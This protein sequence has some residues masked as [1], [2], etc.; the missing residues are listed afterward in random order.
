MNACVVAVF[1]VKTEP[2]P[3]VSTKHM[4]EDSKGLGTN[5]SAPSTALLF[6]GFRS[7]VTLEC[8]EGGK[9]GRGAVALVVV[10]HGTAAAFFHGQPRLGAVQSRNLAFL[11]G[12]QHHGVFRRV[13]V[14]AYDVLHLLGEFRIA[15]E[16]ESSHQVRLQ[17]VS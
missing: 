2:K 15:T 7:S 16:F 10:G 14:E 11:V 6:S 17:P 3:G 1:P 8:V 13:Q 9:Q 4:P 12:A 5:T